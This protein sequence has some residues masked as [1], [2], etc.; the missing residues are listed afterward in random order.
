MTS[1]KRKTGFYT[2]ERCFWHTGGQYALTL[3]VGG[4]MGGI[5]QPLSAGGLPE[6]PETKR[7]LKN[8]LEVSGLITELDVRT[9]PLAHETD[10]LRVH[11][12]SYVTAFKEMSEN[13]GG[14]LGLRTPFGRGGFD[15]ACLSAG[16][17][18]AALDAVLSG[19]IDNAYA[20]SRPP[21]HHCMPDWPNGFCLLNNIAIAIE[22]A[23][24]KGMAQRVVVLDWDVHHGN[25]TEAIYYD[26]DDVLT[27]SIHQEYNYPLDT[28]DIKDRGKG[29]GQN[30]NINI[31]L[32]PGPGHVS[33][34]EAME[35]IILPAIH[36][37]APDVIIVACGFDAAAVDPLS[38]MSCSAE[39]FRQMTRQV[40]TAAQTLCDGKLLMVHEGGYSEAYVPFC[41]HAVIEELCGSGITVEDPLGA[42]VHAR[43]PSARFDAFIS[44]LIDE[45]AQTLLGD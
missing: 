16:L 32:P 2:D 4:P 44:G 36:G 30:K 42:T 25:G 18:T 31:P 9:A 38:R 41:G 3:P 23:Q 7:R 1:P 28:G 35:K 13:G 39:T 43:Q 34:L 22:A 12:Q 26:R 29:Q 6:N 17:A 8:L 19:E 11:P 40:M 24:A 37:H 14:E 20:L 45:M 33:Y 5:V 21:G 27:I 10:L 15:L